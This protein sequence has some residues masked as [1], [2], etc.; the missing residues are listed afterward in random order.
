MIEVRKY[1]YKDYRRLHRPICPYSDKKGNVKEHHYVWWLFYG[2]KDIIKEGEVIHHIN[3]DYLDNRIDN[4]K[5]ISKFEHQ[6]LH[7]KGN[8]Y[9]K[10]IFGSYKIERY[11]EIQNLLKEGKSKKE[12]M[13]ILDIS[14]QNLNYYL[15]HF[16]K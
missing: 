7:K 9:R 4:L 3:E 16:K 10:E 5:K 14:K 15:H 11:M 12:I 13:K 6:S 1:N 2:D 8:T